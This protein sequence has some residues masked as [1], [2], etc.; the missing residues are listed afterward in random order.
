ML[1]INTEIPKFLVKFRTQSLHVSSSIADCIFYTFY[2]Q[3]KYSMKKLEHLVSILQQYITVD[4]IY[5][6]I[7]CISSTVIIKSTCIAE[8]KSLYNC[9][10]I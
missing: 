4:I 5:M 1:S 9:V 3:F 2:C 7:I 10:D 6:Y 8:T